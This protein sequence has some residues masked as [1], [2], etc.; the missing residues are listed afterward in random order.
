MLWLLLS[1]TL[2]VSCRKEDPGEDP[3]TLPGSYT[4]VRIDDDKHHF[5][6]LAN[7]RFITGDNH[8]FGRVF[9][10]TA[11]RGIVYGDIEL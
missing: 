6:G 7:R 1:A 2:M 8:F 9:R 10:S 11:G 5:V 4:W 3:E